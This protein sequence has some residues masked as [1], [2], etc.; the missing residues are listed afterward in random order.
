MVY[1]LKYWTL[2]LLLV[3][4]AC[5]GPDFKVE[6]NRIYIVR[7]GDSLS[8][9]GRM[10]DLH[11]LDLAKRNHIPPPY[12]IYVGQRI[13]L[14]GLSPEGYNFYEKRYVYPNSKSTQKQQDKS[15]WIWP[16]KGKVCSG[17]GIRNRKHHDGIDIL[18]DEG[19]AIRASKAGVVA[20]SGQQRG[21]GNLILIRHKGDLFTAYA[22][23]RRNIARKNDRVRQGE[24]IA[25]VGNTGRAS[26]FHVHFEIRK[27]AKAVNPIS[28]LPHR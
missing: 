17:F 1:P 22:H 16:V 8:H 7:S 2:A 19:V 28:F 27:G 20:F 12:R 24:V 6:D 9:I 14:K 11:Y 10:Y 26:A 23:N 21:Y 15:S 25:E 18:A 3:L 13:Y 5:G 4:T